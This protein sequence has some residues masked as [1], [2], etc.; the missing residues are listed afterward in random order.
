MHVSVN[1]IFCDKHFFQGFRNV[2]PF[3]VKGGPVRT[4]YGQGGFFRCERLHLLVQKT[5]DISKFMVCPH[6]Q[7]GGRFG[8]VRTREEWSSF[9]VFVKMS[10]MD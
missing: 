4:F 9:H 6:G 3:T 8:P 2:L 7:E 1:Y 5:L 10:F